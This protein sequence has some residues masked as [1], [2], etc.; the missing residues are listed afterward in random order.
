L[1]S[2]YRRE[3]PN[4]PQPTFRMYSEILP[5]NVSGTLHPKGEHPQDAPPAKVNVWAGGI[6]ADKPHGAA[7]FQCKCLYLPKRCQAACFGPDF[8]TRSVRILTGTNVIPVPVVVAAIV[9]IIPIGAVCPHCS[10]CSDGGCTIAASIATRVARIA[11]AAGTTG[12]RTAGSTCNR[13]SR[14][15]MGRMSAA[16]VATAP[17]RDIHLR[18][19]GPHHLRHVGRR[20]HPGSNLRSA[21]RQRRVPRGY[22]E[23]WQAPPYEFPP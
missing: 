16:R 4:A 7:R 6:E 21:E 20:H 22:G 3:L 2:C 12:N 19:H 15:G 17:P 8:F 1:G 11:R 23:A 13:A 9:A 5:Q 10:R 18:R 14:Y